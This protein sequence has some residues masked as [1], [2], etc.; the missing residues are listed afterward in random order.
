MLSNDLKQIYSRK[1]KSGDWVV[2][3]ADSDPL[4]VNEDLAKELIEGNLNKE[5]DENIV[6]VFYEGGFFAKNISTEYKIPDENQSLPWKILRYTSLIVGFC[7]L[8][9]ML[10]IT[11]IVGIPTGNRI[12]TNSAPLWFVLLYILGIAVFTTLLHEFMH[13]VYANIWNDSKRHFHINIKKAFSTVSMSH[14]WVWSFWSRFTAL[15]AGLV[16]DL[17]LLMC[18]TCLQ[19]FSDSWLII[20]ASSVLWVRVLWQFRFDKNCDGKLIAMTIM[21]NPMGADDKDDVYDMKE[22]YTWKCLKFLG[23]LIN[24]LLLIFWLIPFILDIIKTY[25]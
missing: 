11:P 2:L 15:A 10:I 1:L 21:D 3:A 6:N 24:M 13:I 14:I 25:L 19:L 9:L 18:L 17:F 22:W 20:A 4:V 23:Y 8:L 12:L 7:S 16:L 5:L